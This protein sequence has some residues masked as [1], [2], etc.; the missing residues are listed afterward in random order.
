MLRYLIILVP[1]CLLFGCSFSSRRMETLTSQGQPHTAQ[2]PGFQDPFL[3]L[4]NLPD[5]AETQSA[6]SEQNAEAD[7]ERNPFEFGKNPFEPAQNTETTAVSADSEGSVRVS[8]LAPLNT[9]QPESPGWRASRPSVT[10]N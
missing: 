1:I 4:M 5:Q 7:Q 3:E 2:R 9:T 10:A 8:D 6:T